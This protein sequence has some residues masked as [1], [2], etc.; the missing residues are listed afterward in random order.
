MDAVTN[1]DHWHH[2]GAHRVAEVTERLVALVTSLDDDE[3]TRQVPGMTWTAHE[4]FAHVVTVWRRY[5]VNPTRSATARGV[6]RENA[7]DLASIDHD[8]DGLVAEL[9]RQTEAMLRLPDLVPPD[10][11]LP[12]HA[13]QALTLAG[14]WGN[15]LNELL[16]HG[17]DIARAT[18]RAWAFD[19]AD[20]EPFWRWT[21]TTL[22]G[23]LT[24]RGAAANDAWRL[25]LGYRTGPVHLRFSGGDVAIDQP[26][27]TPDY[28]DTGDAVQVTLTMPWRRRPTDDPTMLEFNSRIIA[29]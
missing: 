18:S 27:P 1:R 5:T 10:T 14:G 13:Q 21:T 11:R 16:I 25:E 20:T 3:L 24:D 28:T 8:L 22:P 17:D 2:E 19:P 9:R 29:V 23:F 26:D 6:A 7:A 15:A 12:F 4:V